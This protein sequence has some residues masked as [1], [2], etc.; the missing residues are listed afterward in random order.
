[1]MELSKTR[2]KPARDG[3]PGG[4]RR[5]SGG[6]FTLVEM[7]AVILVISILMTVGVMG[8]K[9]LSGGKSTQAAV[10]AAEGLFEEARLAAVGRGTT[11]RVLINTDENK[12]KS[13]EF[14]RRLLVA[15]K[16]PTNNQWVLA[17]RG[18][19]M[20]DGV[21]FS[22]EFSKKDFAGARSDLDTENM[23]FPQSDYSGEYT[24]YEFNSEGVCKSPGSS[25][26]VGAGVRPP[27]GDPRVAGKERDFSGFIVWRNG[28]TSKFRS[29]TQMKLPTTLQ[30][31]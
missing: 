20:P 10:A 5:A 6:G 8:I 24:Y 22:R 27:G 9:N 7:L 26:I 29:P 28:H 4:G 14:L 25:F 1:M 16:D 18:Y 13:P 23:T 12:K 11:A 15:Y 3:A 30:N 31:F 19:L 17:N 2:R 21:F